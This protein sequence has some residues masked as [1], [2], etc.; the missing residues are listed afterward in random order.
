[1]R[2]STGSVR[3]PVAS[4]EPSSVEDGNAHVRVRPALELLASMEPS[5]VEDGNKTISGMSYNRLAASMEPSSVED[6]NES[7]GPRSNPPPD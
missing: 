7:P 6:G 4:M 2:L 5:S 3:P 1:M